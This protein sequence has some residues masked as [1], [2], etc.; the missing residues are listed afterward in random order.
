MKRL[1]LSALFAWMISLT[2]FAQK[3]IAPTQEFVIEGAVQTP[4]TIRIAD[5]L[6]QPTVKI[7]PVQIV[8][9]AGVKKSLL[10]DVRGVRILPLLAQ[11]T[12]NEENSKYWSEFYFIFEASDGYQN[13]YS[14]NE[15]F[16]TAVGDQVYI[17]T[18]RDGQSL[19]AMDGQ[20]V[21][22]SPGD[23]ITGRRYLKGLSKIRVVRAE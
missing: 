16:N 9:H 19:P 11:A 5:I 8:N 4:V 18:A 17:L 20:L 13:V 7:K 14:W 2:A 1:L 15:L 21:V 6:A 22:L 3:D 12:L 23:K 10:K